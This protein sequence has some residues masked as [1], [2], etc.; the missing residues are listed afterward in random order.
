MGNDRLSNLL[1]IG[2]E[3]D[4]AAKINLDDAIDVFLKMRNRRYTLKI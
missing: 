3:R 1:V 4:I 2:I